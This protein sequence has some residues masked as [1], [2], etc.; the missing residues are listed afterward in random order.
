[1][2]VFFD[3]PVKDLMEAT[4]LGNMMGQKALEI[5]D[6]QGAKLS[7]GAAKVL[8]RIEALRGAAKAGVLSSEEA[9][10]MLDKLFDV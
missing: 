3:I 8:T 7:A 5:L 4:Y 2:P 9:G 10:S 1:M 6:S